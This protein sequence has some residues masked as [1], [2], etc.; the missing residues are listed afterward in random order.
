MIEGL[1]NADVLPVLERVL[2]F[3]GQRHRLIVNNIANLNTPGFRPMDVSVKAFQAQ[4]GEAVDARREERGPFGGALNLKESKQVSFTNNRLFLHPEA[5]AN[6]ILFHDGSEKNI[7]RSMQDLVENFSTF[8]LAADLLR[9]RVQ[10][11]E[12]AIRGRI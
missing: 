9:K 8:R 2:Q 4:L 10:L 1:N 7:E 12:T 6:S 5:A 11:L 3:A